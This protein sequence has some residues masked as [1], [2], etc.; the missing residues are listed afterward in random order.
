VVTVSVYESIDLAS[1]PGASRFSEK[2]WVWNVVHLASF[3]NR[4]KKKRKQE[5][6]QCRNPTIRRW[7]RSEKRRLLGRYGV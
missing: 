1:I 4:I 2:K 6:L 7:D 3:V 5:L